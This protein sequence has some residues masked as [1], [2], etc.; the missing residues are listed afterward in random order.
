MP[1]TTREGEA[2]GGHCPLP[3]L[4]AGTDKNAPFC[5][6]TGISNTYVQFNLG[7]D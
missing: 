6:D 7:G 2:A 1:D 4:Y 3:Q 5:A